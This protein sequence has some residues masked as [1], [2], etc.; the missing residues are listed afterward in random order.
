MPKKIF[1]T[2]INGFTGHYLCK[3]LILKGYDLYGISNQESSKKNIFKINLTEKNKLF[4]LL[5]E[6]EPDIVVHLASISSVSNNNFGSIYDTNII[7]SANLFDSLNRIK[8]KPEFILV[9]SSANV[10]GNSGKSVQAESDFLMPANH[11]AISKYAME[12]GAKL[13]KNSLPICI[14]RPFNYTGVGQSIDFLIP[15]I[16]NHYALKKEFIE[17]GNID[18]ERDFSDVRFLSKIYLRLIDLMP[19]GETIN[20][21]SG[22]TY[23]IKKIMDIMKSLSNHDIKVKTSKSLMRPN[24]IYILQG[25]KNKLDKYVGNI[26]PI[27]FEETLEWMYSEQLLK[28]NF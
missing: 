18:V 22:K 8:K 25:S 23:S 1:V 21:C 27:S 4:N 2:G 19:A 24:E 6:I 15:K 3:D 13:L 20:I 10:Y 7:G 9:S 11:Y 28:N 16:V 14:T 17:L 26:L 12:L 5:N